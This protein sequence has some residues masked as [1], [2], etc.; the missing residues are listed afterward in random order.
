MVILG[1]GGFAKELIDVLIR[2]SIYTKEK[3]YF[4]DEINTTNDTLFGF[5]VFHTV[6]EV[7]DAYKQKYTKVT[8]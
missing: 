6:E 1:A 2:D 8:P 4:F 5:K 7:G 3:L